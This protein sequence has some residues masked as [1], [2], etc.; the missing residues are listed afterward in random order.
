[1]LESRSP[2]Q[3][4]SLSSLSMMTSSKW[5]E[6]TSFSPLFCLLTATNGRMG[7]GQQETWKKRET[8]GSRLSMVSR[9]KFPEIDDRLPNFFIAHFEHGGHRQF[10]VDPF[11]ESDGKEEL[12]IWKGRDGI[13]CQVC[14][15]RDEGAPGR[16]VSLARI[17]VAVC[18]V[19]QK[20]T[21]ALL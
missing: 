11:P 10:S 14:W 12:A 9:G 5:A 7:S 2:D 19:S 6:R 1:M 18:A 16:P 8:G 15:W 17:A 13:P 3:V 20:E 21:L 4:C